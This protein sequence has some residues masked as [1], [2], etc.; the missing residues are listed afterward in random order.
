MI[1]QPYCKGWLS[2]EMNYN[3]YS[4]SNVCYVSWHLLLVQNWWEQVLFT[5]LLKKKGLYSVCVIKSPWKPGKSKKKK[6]ELKGSWVQTDGGEAVGAPYL[7][8]NYTWSKE[9]E[10]RKKLK[11]KKVYVWS[12]PTKNKQDAQLWEWSKDGLGLSSAE[13]HGRRTAAVHDETINDNTVL[14]LIFHWSLTETPGISPVKSLGV[15]RIKADSIHGNIIKNKRNWVQDKAPC[16][17]TLEQFY[18]WKSLVSQV[19]LLLLLYYYFRRNWT[20]LKLIV[21]I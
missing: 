11:N 7:A 17:F 1:T 21:F 12:V 3:Q 8:T 2:T 4:D 16:F 9:R 14:W 18:L 10:R 13:P 15:F 19:F 5:G 20:H 6:K